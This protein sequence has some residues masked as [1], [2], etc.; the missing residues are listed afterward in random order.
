[1][2]KIGQAAQS[3]GW[4][5]SSQS[6][7]Q[8]AQSTGWIVSSQSQFFRSCSQRTSP[9]GCWGP[10]TYRWW[11]GSGSTLGSCPAVGW[12]SSEPTMYEFSRDG[13]IQTKQANQVTC[14]NYF[15]PCNAK[16]IYFSPCSAEMSAYSSY[17]E[18]M[19]Y[20]SPCSAKTYD[21][22]LC[23]AETYYKSMLAL[24]HT[25]VCRKCMWPSSPV[26]RMDGKCPESCY[27]PSSPEGS[28]R[29][30]CSSQVDVQ[31]VPWCAGNVRGQAVQSTGWMVSVQSSCYIPC[32]TE[33][34]TSSPS[35]AKM[36]DFVHAVQRRTTPA[37]AMQRCT[38]SAHSVLRRTTSVHAELRCLPSGLAMQRCPPSVPVVQRC[39]TSVHAPGCAVHVPFRAVHTQV[40]AEAGGR[41]RGVR[42]A[43]GCY[44]GDLG[45]CYQG[46]LGGE[47]RE[48]P[49]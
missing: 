25:L 31:A 29:S 37:H 40:H 34:S 43:A 13:G 14:K 32:S 41:V 27:I 22:S 23:N 28:T 39:P 17:C 9:W 30:P 38:T 7:D 42:G 33:G 12:G 11:S 19:S 24:M 44:Q 8:A 16:T 15:R 4:I 1:M 48:K 5:V 35:C 49:H 20:F 36:S 45:G 6:R 46:G 10:L 21:F 2:A 26:H 47:G 18:E 3:T